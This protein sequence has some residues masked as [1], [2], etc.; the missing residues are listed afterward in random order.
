MGKSEF[1]CCVVVVSNGERL[2]VVV[3]SIFGQVVGGGLFV[4]L[5][6]GT[7]ILCCAMFATQ[8]PGFILILCVDVFF[9]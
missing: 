1:L 4:I 9:I 8:V 7:A 3:V 6:F 2:G 5:M